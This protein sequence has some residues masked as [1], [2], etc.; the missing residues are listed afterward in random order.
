MKKIIAF[1]VIF[2]LLMICSGFSVPGFSENSSLVGV[3]HQAFLEQWN[4]QLKENEEYGP[5]IHTGI[6]MTKDEWHD[7]LI[8]E[9]G[10]LFID[11]F[12]D[13]N[14]DDAAIWAGQM[15]VHRS[16]LESYSELGSCLRSAIQ[17]AMAISGYDDII[18]YYE[19]SHA[20]EYHS[21]HFI[22][23]G[24]EKINGYGEN[25]HLTSYVY[26]SENKKNSLQG[27]SVQEFAARFLPSVDESQIESYI[28]HPGMDEVRKKFGESVSDEQLAALQKAIEAVTT[29]YVFPYADSISITLYC[30]PE[31]SLIRSYSLH[32][33]V[34]G[35]KEL[36][37]NY[38]EIFF[39]ISDCS[40]PA[41][42][43]ELLSL[44]NG[45]EFAWRDIESIRNYPM[46]HMWE[47]MYLCDEDWCLYIEDDE[48]GIPSVTF[49]LY[50]ERYER[51]N[52][53]MW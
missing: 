46:G 7:G 13:S 33:S 4:E 9:S 40:L 22:M 8:S 34:R 18:G 44:M 2:L 49:Y 28:V 15:I 37:R 10:N 45:E 19:A 53:W 48:Q 12:L 16:L 14:D 41:Q 26:E 11:L 20:D 23:S 35:G 50:D 3:K 1:L 5:F 31:T 43:I 30:D 32:S 6:F 52:G 36:Y 47:T 21:L 17:N 39:E 27:Y 51:Q 24:S 29:L 25:R 42:T 38:L